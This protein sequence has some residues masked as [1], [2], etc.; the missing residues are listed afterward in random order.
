MVICQKVRKKDQIIYYLVNTRTIWGRKYQ[1]YS[2]CCLHQISTK[3]Y[4][5]IAR[6]GGISGY[7]FVLAI[8]CVLKKNVIYLG[9]G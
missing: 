4:E 8:G 3:L 6:H 1:S 2:C 9:K 7:N 5:D